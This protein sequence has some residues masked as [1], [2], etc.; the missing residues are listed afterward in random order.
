[1]DAVSFFVFR[2]CICR[3]KGFKISISEK[4]FAVGYHVS[5]QQSLCAVCPECIASFRLA[6]LIYTYAD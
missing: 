5:S 1:M 2:F 4:R 3:L 6:D